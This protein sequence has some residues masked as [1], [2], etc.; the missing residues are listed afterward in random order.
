MAASGFTP[1]SLYYSATASAVPLAANLV[2]GELALNT[3]DGKLYYKNSSNVVTLLAS[4]AGSAGDVVGPASA[5]DNALARFDLTTGKLIQNS[6]GILSDAGVLTGLTGL[7]SSGPIT[8]SSLTS[9]R[10]PYATTAGLLTDSANLLYS[11]TDLTVYGLTVGRGLGAV[12]TNTAVGTSA[13]SSNT[14]GS[15][16]VGLGYQALQANTTGYSLVAVGY[17]ALK[18]NTTGTSHVAVGRN[19]LLANTTGSSNTAVGD[20]SLQANTTASNNTAVGYQAGYSNT[21][22]D[23]FAFVGYKAGFANTTGIRVTAIGYSSGAANTTGNYNVFVG[24]YS[25]GANTTGQQ[26]IAVG[27]VAFQQNTTGSYNVVFGFEALSRN[28]TSNSNTAIG[29]QALLFNTSSNNTAV[30]FQAGYANTTGTGVTAIGYVALAANT[31]GQ[32]NTAVGTQALYTST[33]GTD[34]TA[35]GA[36]AMRSATT[37]SYNTAVGINS[38]FSA[39]TGTGLNTAIGRESM[40]STTT[41]SSNTAVGQSALYTN[42]TGT[43]NVAVGIE[44][45]RSNTT[46][47]SNTALGGQAGF[48]ITTGPYN[49]CVGYFAGYALTTGAGNTF[50]GSFQSGGTAGAGS[51]VTTGSKNVIL[52]GYTGSAAPISTTGS[53]YIVLSDGDG[54]L[55]Y[56]VDNSGFANQYIPANTGG[57]FGFGNSVGYYLTLNNSSSA[58]TQYAGIFGSIKTS[59]AGSEDGQFVIGVKKAGTMTYPVLVDSSGNVGIGTTSMT[60]KFNI[61]YSGTYGVYLEGAAGS[62]TLQIFFAGATNVGSISTNGTITAFNT[63]SDYRL[64][65]DVAPMTGALEKVAALKPVTYKWKVDGSDGQGF[66]AHELDEVVPGCVTGQKDA[67]DA[68]GKPVYQGIDVSFLVAT[69]AAAIQELKAEFDAYKS[70]HP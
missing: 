29:T 56:W 23:Q 25:G 52:G 18:A 42:T 48:G 35:I 3:N 22:G 57:G 69:L 34:N 60:G 61:V 8:L 13:L 63:V 65:E 16:V 33:T 59:T 20:Q 32:Q 37:A 67:V 19:A 24:S 31:T 4:T 1:I 46:A 49:T 55:R 30:G 10:V 7:T 26:N 2:A 41:G 11:G 68:D 44:A 17:T 39:T 28:L 53:N 5:T 43:N 38:L 15:E 36:N 62:S 64:K 70:T 50:V 12:A 54:V 47:A 27:D 21:T 6:V 9:G 14:I 45:L 66:I 51:A 40:Y 58:I